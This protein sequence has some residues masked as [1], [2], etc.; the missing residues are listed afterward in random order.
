MRIV[1]KSFLLRSNLRVTDYWPSLRKGHRKIFRK[2]EWMERHEHRISM[3]TFN[4][5]SYWLFGTLQ[6]KIKDA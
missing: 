6:L 4:V 3:K 2:V 5:V 1:T